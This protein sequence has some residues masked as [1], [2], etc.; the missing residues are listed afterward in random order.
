MATNLN[1]VKGDL[2]A[3]G[4]RV[5]VRDMYFG[6]QT[7]KSGLII[8]DDNGSTRGIYPRWGKVYAKGPDNTDE[9]NVGDWIL[10]EHGRWTRGIA[11][12][13]VD[14][15]KIE[16]RMVENESILAY[17]NERPDGLQIGAEFSDGSHATIDAG[18]FINQ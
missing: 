12:E 8:K 6:E 1:A 16:V 15:E 9:F 17:S 13:Q 4:N 5:L 10:I 2:R 7:T 11:L 18:S 14:G 3:V